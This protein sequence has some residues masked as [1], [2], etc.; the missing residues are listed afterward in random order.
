[1]LATYGVITCPPNKPVLFC[2]LASVVCRRHLSSSLTLPE[3]GPAP[4]AWALGWPTLHG[5]PVRLRCLSKTK[6]RSRAEWQ[7]SSKILCRP[8][9]T[10]L[11]LSPMSKNLVLR[12]HVSLRLHDVT[13]TFLRMPYSPSDYLSVRILRNH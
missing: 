5:G 11:F 12:L 8:I 2:S 3:G 13:F 4:G 9:L 1:M 10:S 6:P 7:V